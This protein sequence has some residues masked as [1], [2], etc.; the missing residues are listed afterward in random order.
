MAFRILVAGL[1][2]VCCIVAVLA[3]VE[4]SARPGGSAIGRGLLFRGAVPRPALQPSVHIGRAPALVTGGAAVPNFHPAHVAP[5][6][7]FR[8]VFGARLPRNGIGVYYGSSYDP[9]DVI[10]AVGPVAP[11]QAVADVAAPREGAGA[12]AGGRRCNSQT[13]VVPS[14]A[15]GERP[16]TITRCRSQ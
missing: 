10:G 5:M 2:A 13:V 15:G 12:V 3:P 9:G 6:Q 1:C 4:A 8:R 7:R 14:E 11:V 16:I